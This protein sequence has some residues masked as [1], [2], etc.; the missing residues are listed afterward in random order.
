M[1]GIS[2]KLPLSMDGHDGA[3]TLNKTLDEVV[4]QN[5]KMLLLTIPGERCMDINFGIGIERYLFEN[6][7]PSLREKL[8]TRIH[9][10]VAKYMPFV[11]VR[12]VFYGGLDDP[13]YSSPNS[14][15]LTLHYHVDPISQDDILNIEL[16]MVDKF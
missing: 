2:C 12:D 6:D 11:S 5:L 14:L 4:K 7:T 8:S 3:Y 16:P 10:Q 9:E 15:N 1:S 13:N